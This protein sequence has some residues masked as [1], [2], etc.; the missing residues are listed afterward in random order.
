MV[1]QT[2]FY[3]LFVPERSERND[4]IMKRIVYFD[5]KTGEN[6]PMIVN[7]SRIDPKIFENDSIIEDSPI[8]SDIY[9]LFGKL[10]ECEELINSY[11]EKRSINRETGQLF[12]AIKYLICTAHAKAEYESESC[13]SSDIDSFFMM[14]DDILDDI[15][16]HRKGIHQKEEARRRQE[17]YEKECEE[18]RRRQEEEEERRRQEE[19]E[20]EERRRRR[21]REEEEE[22]RRRE[23]YEEEERYW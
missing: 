23:R 10:D 2:D 22:R 19:E 5:A 7:E 16:R 17:E 11:F 9:S 12:D 6:K 1:S 15:Q 21:R 3:F 14:I 20:E 18:E 8:N 13:Y 4:R